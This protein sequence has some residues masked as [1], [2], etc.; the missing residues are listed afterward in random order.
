M[1]A[2]DAQSYWISRKIPTDQFLLYCFADPTDGLDEI[3][4]ALL[5]RAALI[6]DLRVKVGEIPLRADYPHWVPM[7]V[8][9]GHVR[10]HGSGPRSWDRCRDDVA[11]L[12]T[13]RLDPTES[14]WRLHLFGPVHG[15][16]RCDD[17]PA[18]VA[19]LQ[20]VHAL[21]DGTRASEIARALFSG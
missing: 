6:P 14:P 7:A 11:A 12:L 8:E 21:A 16:P 17:G 3:R 15:A 1:F 20:V 19:V 9:S 2:P 13:G 18:V 10:L 4:A 5:D